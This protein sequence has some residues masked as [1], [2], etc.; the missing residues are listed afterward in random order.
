MKTDGIMVAAAFAGMFTVCFESL[1]SC[2]G[3]KRNDGSEDPVLANH[4]NYC[5][6]FFLEGIITARFCW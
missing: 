5:K 6:F 1:C 3:S 2:F 4:S